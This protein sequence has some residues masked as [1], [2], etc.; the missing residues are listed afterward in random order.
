[1]SST[2]KQ[3]TRSMRSIMLAI[4]FLT[5]LPVRLKGVVSELDIA[6]CAAFFPFVGAVQGFL[7]LVSAMAMIRILPADI[8][9]GFIIA[10]AIISNGGFHLD[11]LADSFDALAV[12]SSGDP[13]AD[14]EKR[15][16]VMKDSSTGAIGV[17]AIV[18]VILL[19]FVLI[20]DVLL[21]PDPLTALL[22]LFLMPVYSKW[23]MVPA[24]YHGK[25]ARHDGLGKIF[26]ES[27]SL[28]IV[29]FS[30]ALAIFIFAIIFAAHPAGMEGLRAPLIFGLLL[31]GYL[32]ARITVL[33]CSGKFSGLTGDTLGALSE[34][35]EILYLT[36][37]YLWLQ[38]SI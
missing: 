23:I 32:L 34:L 14:R 19:K 22:I 10:I 31:A 8:V 21:F 20:K 1:M 7:L 2:E 28:T 9:S 13:A 6:R 26:V 24:M 11:G 17:I 12:K 35:S 37:S 15:L 4:Q 30:S 16:S 38:H 5:I 29:M 36:G 18:M 33:F 3:Q 25:S 27:V